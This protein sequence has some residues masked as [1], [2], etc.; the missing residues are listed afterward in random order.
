MI[1]TRTGT[2]AV[3]V[4]LIMRH[5]LHGHL[6]ESPKNLRS[7]ISRDWIVVLIRDSLALAEKDLLKKDVDHLEAFQRLRGQ[8]FKKSEHVL[9]E[10][11]ADF[12]QR[13]IEQIHY[14]FGTQPGDM[15]I[16]IHLGSSY[17]REKGE[18]SDDI[19]T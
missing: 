7:E 13:E 6:G 9:R 11:I 5:F 18:R 12:L 2:L 19:H 15:D 8:L 17:A 3:G 10:R 14:I 4:D 1:E 16:I